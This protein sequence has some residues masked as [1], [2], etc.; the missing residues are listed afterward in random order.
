MKGRKLVEKSIIVIFSMSVLGILSINPAFAKTQAKAPFA[1]T[2]QSYTRALVSTALEKVSQARAANHDKKINETTEPLR[3]VR[4][5]FD[6]IR[7]SRPTAEVQGLLHYVKNNL[8]FEDNNQVLADLL[9][10]YAALD[11]MAPSPVVNTVHKQLNVVKKA[12]ENADRQKAVETLNEINQALVIDN[13][14]IP[15]NAA[16]QDLNTA[17]HTLQVQGKPARDETLLSIEK[18]LLIMLNTLH[19]KPNG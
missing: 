19:S 13:V 17:I 2:L 3:D 12:L 8:L 16:I 1:P 6:L 15:L 5:L 11:A 4:L 7:A 10:V 9:T 14:D 18:N